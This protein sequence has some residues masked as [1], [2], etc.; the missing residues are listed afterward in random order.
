MTTTPRPLYRALDMLTDTYAPKVKGRPPFWRP[1]AAPCA[2]QVRVPAW[3]WTRPDLDPEAELVTLDVNAAYLAALSSAT[4]AHGALVQD[5]APDGRAPGYYLVD[6]HPWQDPRMPSPLGLQPAD[7]TRVWIAHPTLEVLQ[8]LTESE[9]GYWPEVR[10]HD[11][12]TSPTSCR[13]RNWTTVIRNDRAAAVRARTAAAGRG[14]EAAYADADADYEAIK[15][16]YSQAVQL[17]RGPQEGEKTK[18]SVH[19]PDWY[20][21]VH[22][23]HAANMWRRA[24][25]T[26]HIGHGPA[27]MG[28]TDSIQWTADDLH[29]IR[30]RCAPMLKI[31]LTRESIG[32][33]KIRD[34]DE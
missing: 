29:A 19:R 33:L 3:S 16:G 24:W 4:F 10:I 34:D 30:V 31:D 1:R 8:A 25:N 13:L 32:T 14:D 27:W 28:A 17:M 15:L 12:W 18:S 2:D 9:E 6:V 7:G 5:R 20:A 21:T 23:Q 11:A 26:V 22:A